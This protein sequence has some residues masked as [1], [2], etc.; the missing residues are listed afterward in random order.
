MRFD[1]TPL[2]TPLVTS[3]GLIGGFAAARASG[4]RAVGGAVLGVAGAAA[5]LLARRRSGTAPATALTAG[6]LTAFGVSHPL[7]K[8]IGPWPSVVAVTGAVAAAGLLLRR[9]A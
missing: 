5:F 4:V 2:A 1:T 9:G 6:Y 8:R 3:A 7:A